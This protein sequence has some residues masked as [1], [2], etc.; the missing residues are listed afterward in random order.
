[1]D[2]VNLAS[3]LFGR[4][5][6]ESDPDVSGAVEILTATAATNSADGSAGVLLDC[7]VTPPDDYE[8]D[9]A[10]LDV[11]TS[12]SALAGDDLL[13]G[14]TGSG[15]LKTPVVLSNPGF[16]DRVQ[17]VAS[18]AE[19]LA[20]LAQQVA[21]AVSQHFW[22]DS[23]GAHVTQVTEEEWNDSSGTEY[24]S[25]PNSLWNSAGMLFRDGLTNLLAVLTSGIAIYD[26]NGNAASNIIAEFVGNLVRIGGTFASSGLS[27]AA[28]QFFAD[29]SASSSLTAEH[30]IDTSQDMQVYH[31]L[32]LD[33]TT[34]DARLI[35]QSRGVSDDGPLRAHDGDVEPTGPVDPDPTTYEHAAYGNAELYQ[36]VY[37]DGTNWSEESMSS[38]LARGSDTLNPAIVSAHVIRDSAGT[39]RR[40]VRLVG[41]TL[42]ITKGDGTNATTTDYDMATLVSLLNFYVTNAALMTSALSYYQTL[43]TWE[44]IPWGSYMQS[45]NSGWS[46]DSST[47][48]SI[49]KARRRIVGQIKLIGSATHASGNNTVGYVKADYKPYRRCLIMTSS[50]QAYRIYLDYADGKMVMVLPSQET[51]TVNHWMVADYMI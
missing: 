15:P 2:L 16:G 42:R 26:G 43:D 7:D 22:H 35:T 20:A 21:S 12:P 50:T 25:G 17:A 37:N 13:V 40:I 8:G 48:L 11:P 6:A 30:Y 41:N 38:L 39:L 46:L 44:A 18:Q 19:T 45:I 28:V 49:N 5:R 32:I 51:G 3:T 14:L 1:M 33:N 36:M 29:D 34:T 9:D 31:E 24:H 27:S 23:S 4:S 47:V 10:V